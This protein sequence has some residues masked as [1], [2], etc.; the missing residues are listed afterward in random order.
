MHAGAVAVDHQAAEVAG[1]AAGGDG[2]NHVGI[3]VAATGDELLGAV[4][5]KAVRLGAQARFRQ[6]EVRTG[7][8]F[9]QRQRRD[10]APGGDVAQVVL[11][12]MLGGLGGDHRG[13]HAMHAEAQRRGRQARPI[14]S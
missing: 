10:M 2:G 8:L 13:G 14:A 4:D 1:L 5:D 6:V 9:G 3:G 12:L 7:A 11:A